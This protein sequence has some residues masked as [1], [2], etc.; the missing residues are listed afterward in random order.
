[1]SLVN[2]EAS[3]ELINR[4]RTVYEKMSVCGT[5]TG[6]FTKGCGHERSGSLQKANLGV[7]IGIYFKQLKT[8]MC[9]LMVCT[10]LSVPAFVLFWS[11]QSQGSKSTSSQ[12]LTFSDFILGLSL[13]NLGEQAI[14]TVQ[15]DFADWRQKV[16]LFC[17][18]G[19]IGK[20]N[21][22]G[23]AMIERFDS[24]TYFFEDTFCPINLTRENNRA[25]KEK[26]A[27]S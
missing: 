11:G 5:G 17:E 20:I 15:L 2:D 1:M 4:T 8:L 23:I 27:K 18:T 26:C 7:G 16:E 3:T 6:W 25:I 19:V 22:H 14:N 10:I 12:D 13:G 9:M 21:R 24:D